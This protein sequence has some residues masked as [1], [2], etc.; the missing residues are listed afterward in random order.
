MKNGLSTNSINLVSSGSTSEQ[1][2]EDKITS[3]LLRTIRDELTKDESSVP[4]NMEILTKEVEKLK[5]SRDDLE[6]KVKSV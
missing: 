1:S 5:T 6:N 4:M 2:M 3:N